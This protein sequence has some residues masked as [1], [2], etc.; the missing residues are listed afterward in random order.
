MTHEQAVH[1]LLEGANT[2]FDPE[3]VEVLIGHV[4]G[5]RQASAYLVDH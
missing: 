2:Q 1:E 5:L 3:V 4:N